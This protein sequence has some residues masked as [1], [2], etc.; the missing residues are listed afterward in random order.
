MNN[1]LVVNVTPDPSLVLLPPGQRK[2]RATEVH[3]LRHG[4][5]KTDVAGLPEPRK[6]SPLDLVV[7]ASTG[8]IPLWDRG[9]F[10]RW[11]F[12]ERSLDVFAEPAAAK[13]SIT[14]LFGAA[15]LQWGDACPVK[16]VHREER[17]DFEIVMSAQDDCDSSGCV[18]AS[19][20][21]PDGGRHEL[22]IYPKLFTLSHEERVETLVHEIGHVFGLRH[23]FAQ[24]KE[25]TWRS[26][27][28]GAHDP[29]SIMNYGEKSILTAQDR[30]DLKT[31]Y[32]R[33]WSR[34]LIQING[35]QIQLVKPFSAT[36]Q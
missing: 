26:E 8:K 31:L 17:W 18:L 7:D 23:F 21:F 9:T 15:V 3:R 13:T 5:C 25:K 20:F 12:Q 4:V 1:S 29:F 11:R 2:R 30:T 33:A 22:V 6:L 10:L 32:T 14:K 27:I 35:T 16:F 36:N 34:D 19:A 28:F 24:I